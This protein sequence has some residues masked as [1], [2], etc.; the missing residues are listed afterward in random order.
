[1]QTGMSVRD[2][3][4]VAGGI[5]C[6]VLAFMGHASHAQTCTASATPIDFG[7]IRPTIDDTPQAH[8]RVEVRCRWSDP[9]LPSHVRICVNATR[10]D[11]TGP[12]RNLLHAAHAL[13][14]QLELATIADERAA[15]S[16]SHYVL[17]RPAGASTATLVI[18]LAARILAGQRDVF[19]PNGSAALYEAPIDAADLHISYGFFD[20][21]TPACSALP[22]TAPVLSSVRARVQNACTISASD[23]SFGEHGLLTKTIDATSSIHV[24]CSRQSAFRIGLSAGSSGD[25]HRRTM[26]GADPSHAVRYQLF[27]DAARQT[28]WGDGTESGAVY[29]GVGQGR[30]QAVAVHGRIPPQ[31]SVP[32]G[33]YSDHIIATI[34]F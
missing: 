34:Y 30:D 32:P 13:R 24:R 12:P 20:Y 17:N 7:V 19:A 29:E 25:I 33:D 6:V 1:M 4:R 26:R 3:I 21:E 27:L 10:L 22:G 31:A 11:G 15:S 8:G 18:P 5:A 2:V 28:P 16:L 23:L 9:A 14:Y